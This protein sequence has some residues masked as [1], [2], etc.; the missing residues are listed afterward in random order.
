[1]KV[2]IPIV[3]LSLPRA[4]VVRDWGDAF[5]KF[6]FARI[7][8]HGLENQQLFSACRSFFVQSLREKL[9]F[10]APFYGSNG[11]TPRG[12]ES[13]QRSDGKNNKSLPDPVESLVWNKGKEKK[14]TPVDGFAWKYYEDCERLVRNLMGRKMLFSS[15]VLL[16]VHQRFSFFFFLKAITAESIGLPSTFFDESFRDPSCALRVAN[17][18]S[19]AP[20]THEFLYGER[21]CAQKNQK[22]QLNYCRGAHGLHWFYAIVEQQHRGIGSAA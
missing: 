3:D 19:S 13:V 14:P 16:C 12:V 18:D 22:Q 11:Y 15:F 8:N 7:S 1:M 4:T 10:Q 20:S 9:L 6:G 17:Y 2:S 5:R 21:L